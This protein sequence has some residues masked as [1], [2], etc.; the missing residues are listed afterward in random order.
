ME[1]L[2]RLNVYESNPD[3]WLISAESFNNVLEHL[4]HSSPRFALFTAMDLTAGEVEASRSSVNKMVNRGLAYFC[5]FGENCEALHDCLDHA[6]VVQTT[7]NPEPD[8]NSV[9]MTTWHSDDTLEEALWFFLYTAL[10]AG[11]YAQGCENYIIAASTRYL[12]QLEALI[13]KLIG[14]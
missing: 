6:Y 9:L 5:A 12:R 10:P 14:K 8:A 11:R 3:L 4:T 13:P 2:G 1:H 7:M